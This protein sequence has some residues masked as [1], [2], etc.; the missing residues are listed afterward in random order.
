MC[1]TYHTIIKILSFNLCTSN[2]VINNGSIFNRNLCH[3]NIENNYFLHLV[4]IN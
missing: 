4:K 3:W 1:L 2:I